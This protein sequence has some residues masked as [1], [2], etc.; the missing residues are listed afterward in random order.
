MSSATK[1]RTSAGANPAKTVPATWLTGGWQAYNGAGLLRAVIIDYSGSSSS[2]VLTGYDGVVATTHGVA[3]SAPASAIQI[4]TRSSD[5]DAGTTVP[6]T[7]YTDGDLPA[8]T[9]T[10]NVKAGLPFANGLWINKT[11]D[12][13]HDC[14]MTVFIKPLIKKSVNLRYVSGSAGSGIGSASVFDGPGL[15]HGIR[16]RCDIANPSTADFIVKD[17]AIT[18]PAAGTGSGNQLLIKTDYATAAEAVRPVVTLTGMDEGGTAVTTAATGAYAS[19]GIFFASGLNVTL[20]GGGTGE[21]PYQF[22]FLI[23]A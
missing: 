15:L 16:I 4:W 12:T 6:V 9:S 13:T 20:T 22:D 21:A 23:E 17:S 10:A 3:Q 19:P 18:A 5:T 7:C 14:A 8:G 11:G 1:V 2:C